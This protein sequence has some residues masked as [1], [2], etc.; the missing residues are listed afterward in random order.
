VGAAEVLVNDRPATF[1]EPFWFV[2]AA[3]RPD[4]EIVR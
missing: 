1:T 3:F 4:A 2:V